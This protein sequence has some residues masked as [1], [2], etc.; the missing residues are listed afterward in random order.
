MLEPKKFSKPLGVLNIGIVIVTSLFILI[1]FIGYWRWGDE[2]K[3]S[4]TLNLPEGE[5]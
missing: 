2:V 5:M 4:V 1:G 3:G